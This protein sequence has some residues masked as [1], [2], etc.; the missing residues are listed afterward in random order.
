MS[1][2][3]R[4][5]ESNTGAGEHPMRKWFVALAV[6]G[7][8]GVSAFLLTDKGRETIRQWLAYVQDGP[9][10]WDEWNEAAQEELEHIRTALNRIAQ[11]LEPHG[12]VSQ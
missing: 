7:V 4:F 12:E 6:L 10:R 11:S 3:D 1:E 8:G 9:E 2:S 5:W